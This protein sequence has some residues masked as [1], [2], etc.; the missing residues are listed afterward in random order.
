MRAGWPGSIDRAGRFH[1]TEAPPSEVFMYR[2]KSTCGSV[3]RVLHF[4]AMS[5]GVAVSMPKGE[6]AGAATV[7]PSVGE[8]NVTRVQAARPRA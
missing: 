7:I 3:E 2:S 6:G 1:G 4:V 5:A 8:H